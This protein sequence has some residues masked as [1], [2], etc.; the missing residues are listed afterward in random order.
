MKFQNSSTLK[1]F[2]QIH[3][4]GSSTAIFASYLG[5]NFS[6]FHL[7]VSFSMIYDKQ[8]IIQAMQQRNRERRKLKP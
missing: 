2:L 7:T 6:F 3:A 4:S 1:N 5:T 8:L